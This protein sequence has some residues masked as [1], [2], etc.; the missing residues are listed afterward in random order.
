M[1]CDDSEKGK[2]QEFQEKFEEIINNLSGCSQK[3]EKVDENLE[4][5]GL[6]FFSFFFLLIFLFIVLYFVLF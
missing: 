3:E 4:Q 6:F 5:D 1:D 2:V